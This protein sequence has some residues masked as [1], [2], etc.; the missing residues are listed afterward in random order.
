L[1]PKSLVAEGKNE[2][3]ISGNKLEAADDERGCETLMK[4][5]KKSDEDLRRVSTTLDALL[6]GSNFLQKRVSNIVECSGREL[7]YI[8]ITEV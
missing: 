7:H 8:R 3:P 5:G 6:I 2:H 4:H 1:L